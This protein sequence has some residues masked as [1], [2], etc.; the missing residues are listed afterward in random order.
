MS[1]TLK[2]P[3][4]QIHI[5]ELSNGKKRIL[6]LLNKSL[7]FM[8]HK[9]CE[10][11][12]PVELI[13][14]ILSVKG[15]AWLCDEIMRD[16]DPSY[17]QMHLEK[18][19][20]GYIHGGSFDNKRILDF[21]CGGGASTMVLA[22][23]F[24]KTQIV[25]IDLDSKLLSIAKFRVQHYGFHNV[26]FILSP[27][28]MQFPKGIGY[29]DFV[30]LCGVYEHF[31]PNERKLLMPQI[32]SIIKSG[33]VLFVNQTPNRYS[34]IERHT[35]GLPLI[36]YF[37]NWMALAVA[38]RFSKRVRNTEPWE[39]LLRRGVRGGGREIIEILRKKCHDSPILL[40]PSRLELRDRI[41]LWYVLSSST[42]FP[43]VKRLLKFIFKNLKLIS[44]ITFV[45]SLSL[46]IKKSKGH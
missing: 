27:N 19:I 32:W 2:H 29:F 38:R 41:D 21:G 4:A 46:A 7:M 18:A 9:C 43:T 36:N 24:P 44:G 16:E 22:K 11:S 3:D 45:P 28:S 26:K 42:R 30:I 15:P 17:V 23:M 39:T 8:P 37:P 20:L 1:I 35:T 10:T 14:L 13:Q 31:L 33:G 12:Y 25:G 34:L 40:E 6:V 5:D